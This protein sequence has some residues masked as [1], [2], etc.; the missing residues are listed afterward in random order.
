MDKGLLWL[1]VGLNMLGGQARHQQIKSVGECGLRSALH[2]PLPPLVDPEDDDQEGKN[3]ERANNPVNAVVSCRHW[4]QWSG[5][6]DDRCW[7]GHRWRVLQLDPPALCPG[8][9][10]C[11][12]RMLVSG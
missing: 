8:S 7:V 5:G 10:C 6:S 2:F 3:R 12:L 11:Q 4:N 9:K 1:A